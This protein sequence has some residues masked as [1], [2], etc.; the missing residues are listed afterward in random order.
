MAGSFLSS[1]TNTNYST[2]CS[3]LYRRLLPT[4]CDRDVQIMK[5]PE[6]HQGYFL[7]TVFSDS[8]LQVWTRFEGSRTEA[9]S[10]PL[11]LPQVS[12]A[13]IRGSKSKEIGLNKH[14]M[15]LHLFRHFIFITLDFILFA[16]SSFRYED[17]KVLKPL[18]FLY[19]INKLPYTITKRHIDLSIQISVVF[20]HL[21]D[22]LTN[23]N[24]RVN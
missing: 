11:P 10:P 23:Y 5:K 8:N 24:C 16:I 20:L 15:R 19:F 13:T 12:R 17:W 21:M 1:N 14:I 9:T 22:K 7:L 4:A 18:H 3:P 2:V 6:V